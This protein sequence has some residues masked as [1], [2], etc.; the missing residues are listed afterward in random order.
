MAQVQY[1]SASLDLQ[2][3]TYLL[4]N[5]INIYLPQLQI[6]TNIVHFDK[7]KLF[8]NLGLPG[9]SFS[10]ETS[11]SFTI[12]FVI[13]R[14]QGFDQKILGARRYY[15]SDFKDYILWNYELFYIKSNNGQLISQQVKQNKIKFPFLFKQND[16]L[17]IFKTLSAGQVFSTDYINVI[18]VKF[19]STDNQIDI[20]FN[21]IY[22]V[23][24]TYLAFS[25]QCSYLLSTNRCLVCNSSQYS[26]DFQNNMDCVD[27]STL[28]Q[29]LDVFNQ[30]L[31]DRK[32]C[33]KDQFNICNNCIYGDQFYKQGNEC[34]RCPSYCNGCIDA[35]TCKQQDLNRNNLGKCQSGYFDD[36]FNCVLV[37]FLF[38]I[39]IQR[40]TIKNHN[41]IIQQNQ[42]IFYSF[43]F[44]LTQQLAEYSVVSILTDNGVDVFTILTI[45]QKIH[46]YI[47]GKDAVS[48][49][50][51]QSETTWIG[52]YTNW[53]VL[54]LFVF[55]EAQINAK[56]SS[57]I[58]SIMVSSPKI[59]VCSCYSSAFPKYICANLGERPFILIKDIPLI[60]E[61]TYIL[62]LM[63]KQLIKIAQ[64]RSTQ[65]SQ[66][67][68]QFFL[69]NQN[70]KIFINFQ[71]SVKQ[72]DESK[73]FLLDQN[74]WG[75][76]ILDTAD[77]SPITFSTS[78]DC[79][80]ST[81]SSLIFNE[82][83]FLLILYRNEPPFTTDYSFLQ[84]DIYCN[85]KNEKLNIV[86]SGYQLSFVSNLIL[87]SQNQLDE[88]AKY[89]NN[90]SLCTGDGYLYPDYT[91]L[92]NC[93]IYINIM[94]K[95]C[96]LAKQG[97]YQ[98]NTF[99][100][101]CIFKCLIQNDFPDQQNNCVCYKGYFLLVDS[102]GNKQCKKCSN[103]CKTKLNNKDYCLECQNDNLKTPQCQCPQDNFYLDRNDQCQKCSLQCKICET[104]QNN[105]LTCANGRTNPPLC[106]CDQGEYYL[107]GNQCLKR[108][109]S[110]KYQKCLQ[111]L[112][113]CTQCSQFRENP[114]ICNCQQGYFQDINENCLKCNFNQYF[115]TNLKM[116]IPCLQPCLTCR[117]ID[118]NCQ[119]CINRYILDGN[120]C[121]CPNGSISQLSE[122]GEIY[123]LEQMDLSCQIKLQQNIY[124]I[125]LKFE[126]ILNYFDVEQKSNQIEVTSIYIPQIDKSP[127]S[128][129]NYK[130]E[131]DILSFD[132]IPNASFLALSVKLYIKYPQ[133]FVSSD[134]KYI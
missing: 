129:A 5:S 1:N 38:K 98:I 18:D 17:G 41:I 55:T 97:Y 49:D 44:S 40:F 19:G 76:I 54:Q 50:F 63:S 110:K 29:N 115:D 108:N 67:P 118:S 133:I 100:G 3:F 7:K 90:I 65:S 114:P 107:Q 126:P 66:Q 101:E 61:K 73:G 71:E 13:I 37:H 132:F 56:S 87:G 57:I 8:I 46:V 109:C 27:Q 131:G 9:N 75:Q 119:S 31:C 80:D 59:C 20:K 53:K 79:V 12:N 23:K 36:G 39:K 103:K 30:K 28:T 123:C 94:P 4:G 58:P 125:T 22:I 52:I 35:Q 11:C 16:N 72:I 34:F 2:T 10:I 42:S 24:G 60:K 102:A 74:T 127:F 43:S 89:L 81:Y 32:I 121:K 99:T 111:D 116:C 122:K 77:Q 51:K 91:N 86:Q 64:F 106:E 88:T 47:L 70:Q 15:L 134:N 69:I 128:I 62:F 113:T 93:F 105:C 120:V 130:I 26:I 96:L 112:N 78:Q 14:N 84:F 104:N 83:N 6:N 124:K 85:Y 48:I 33:P 95:E 45:N 117:Q 82:P 68:Q 21:N 25:Q 92:N